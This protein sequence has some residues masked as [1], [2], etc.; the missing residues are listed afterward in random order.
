MSQHPD[1]VLKV[2]DLHMVAF[3]NASRASGQ[4]QEHLSRPI[5][6]GAVLLQC[7]VLGDIFLHTY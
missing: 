3:K 6:P 2:A 1:T 5:L 4:Q 7:A